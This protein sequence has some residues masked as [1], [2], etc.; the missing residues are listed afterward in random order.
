VEQRVRNFC[1]GF[2]TEQPRRPALRL[3][4]DRTAGW[5]RGASATG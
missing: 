4:G 1:K 2:S 3:G 5:Q